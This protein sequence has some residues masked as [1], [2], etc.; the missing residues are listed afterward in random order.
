MNTPACRLPLLTDKRLWATLALLAVPLVAQAN[1]GT[2]M[3]W[4]GFLHLFVGNALIGV[5]EGLLMGIV[6]RSAK[7]KAIGIMVAANYFSAWIGYVLILSLPEYL[8]TVTLENASGWMAIFMVLAF[9]VTLVLELPWV[10]LYFYWVKAQRPFKKAVLATLLV[11]VV[12]YLLL[13]FG[14]YG[15]I[16]DMSLVRDLEQVS[17]A[18]MRLPPECTL[19]YLAEDGRTVMR[20]DQNGVQVA[21]V[22]AV[23][24]AKYELHTRENQ[25]GDN[26]YSL[27]L[28]DV[29]STGRDSWSVIADNFMLYRKQRT[30]DT[31]SVDGYRFGRWI[32][33]DIYGENEATGEKFSYRF[34]TLFIRGFIYDWAVVDGP[35]IIFRLEMG[36]SLVSDIC[37]LDPVGKKIAVVARGRFPVV[38]RG[39]SG[40]EQTDDTGH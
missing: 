4:M 6:F 13:W 3:M 8:V 23:K 5:I 37:I 40:V 32:Y 22:G 10:S 36:Y 17:V 34:D 15:W 18:E 1:T 14:C 2:P 7:W 16:S 9:I 39:V 38:A 27:I 12:S 11:N 20:L 31:V 24:S 33:T 29:D 26:T 30:V 35:L 25:D 19:Y 21:A 28:D